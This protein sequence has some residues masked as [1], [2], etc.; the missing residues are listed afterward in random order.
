[1]GGPGSGGHCVNV[2]TDHL[3]PDAHLKHG[4][5]ARRHVFMK[6]A[7]CV[8]NDECEAYQEG[9]GAVCALEVAHVQERRTL[10]LSQPGIDPLL[11][12]PA[13]D[14]ALFAE[15]RVMRGFRFLARVGELQP[16]ACE[17]YG[18]YTPIATRLPL[19]VNSWR[20]CLE[21]L[22][23]TPAARARLKQ[24]AENPAAL[25]WA[26]ALQALPA[27]SEPVDPVDVEVLT[28][29]DGDRD[30]GNDGD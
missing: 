23:L 2:K 10:L 24:T 4:A 1:M 26:A 21:A 14:V 30:N 13:V 6:C 5:T 8:C 25:A 29:E 22:A 20:H 12:G 19:I 3:T 18:E 27:A 17:G 11:D 7:R 16:G 28:S 15:L 9:E